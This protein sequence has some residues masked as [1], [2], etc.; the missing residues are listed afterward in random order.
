[1]DE[2]CVYKKV[3]R[4]QLTFL[5]LYVNNILLIGNDIGMLTS[6][7]VWL[8]KT[9]LMKDLGE[10]T[11]ILKIRVYRDRTKRIIGLSQSLYL[12]KVLKRFNMLDSKRGLLAFG[13]GIHLSKMMPPKIYEE[14]AKM[15]KIP[16][17]SAIGSLMYAMFVSVDV[18]Y[19]HSCI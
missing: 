4:S 12:E 13:H 17:T 15:A 19:G 3:S 11:Y 14:M 5:V 2:P 1:M 16:Y 7:K 10:A 8:S 6:M 9:F 18:P